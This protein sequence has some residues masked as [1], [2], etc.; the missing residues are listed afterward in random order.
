VVVFA[1]ILL[2]L[3]GTLAFFALEH[4][5]A[6]KDYTIP[7][8]LLI[9]F[10]NSVTPRTAGFSTLNVGGLAPLTLLMV[11]ALMFIG[12]S[13]GGTGGG[14]KTT[15]AVVFTGFIKKAWRGGSH[16]NLFH[17]R[18]PNGLVDKALAITAMAFALISAVT[19]L[20]VLVDKLPVLPALFETTSAFA[21]VGLSTG[22]TPSLS[23][24]AKY[25]LM[26]TM[27]CGRVGVLTSLLVLSRSRKTP[28]IVLPEGELIL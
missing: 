6:L 18:I 24:I 22:I 13:P 8:K 7:E 26:F 15:T 9:S 21:T 27:Y 10:F 16:I 17:K 19:C 1:T 20:L 2:L 23:P 11:I 5:N 4:N 25:L 28:E 14:I 3:T 12:A